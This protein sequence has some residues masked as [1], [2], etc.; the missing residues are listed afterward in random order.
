MGHPP[1]CHVLPPCAYQ[2]IKKKSYL[3]SNIL[4]D[5][6][7]SRENEDKLVDDTV[8]S[9]GGVGDSRC[10]P[11]NGQGSEHRVH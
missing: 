5:F 1:R 2:T 7:P 11:D 10:A 8:G 3:I 9:L 4:L 6:M